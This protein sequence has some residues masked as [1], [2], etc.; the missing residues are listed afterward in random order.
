MFLTTDGDLSV[1]AGAH[2]TDVGHQAQKRPRLS[3]QL[4]DIPRMKLLKSRLSKSWTLTD[5]KD[6]HPVPRF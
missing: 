5:D 3:Q 6:I 1:F 4:Q 2:M